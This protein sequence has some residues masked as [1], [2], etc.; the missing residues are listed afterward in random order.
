MRGTPHACVRRFSIAFSYYGLILRATTVPSLFDVFYTNAVA[1]SVE[2]PA[3]LLNI[4]AIDIFGRKRTTLALFLLLAVGSYSVIA[5][6]LLPE[7][8]QDSYVLTLNFFGRAV[9]SA[10]FSAV[11]LWSSELFPTS[12]RHS[13]MGFGS[14]SARIGSVIAPYA[15]R[16]GD[17]LTFLPEEARADVPLLLFGTSAI[18]SGT[19]G[20]LLLPETLGLATPETVADVIAQ[21]RT[22]VHKACGCC[23][24]RRVPA[25][26]Q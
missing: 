14:M 20:M 6:T 7:G 5:V 15:A 21:A 3:M 25:G 9:S 26:R 13:A 18:I 8:A 16:I 4:V 23:R 2:L 24:R 19:L 12:L 22:Q 11:Y 17:V 10:G 1:T